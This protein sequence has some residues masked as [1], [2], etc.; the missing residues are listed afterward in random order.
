MSV[1]KPTIAELRRIAESYGFDLSEAD[2]ETLSNLGDGTLQSYAR[3]DQ[4]QAPKLPVKYPRNAGW[5]PTAQENPHNAWAWRCSIKGSGE[6]LL[7]GR[8]VALKDNICL[9]G[10]PMRN[11]SNVLDGFVPDEDATVVTRI[12]DAGGE[13]AGKAVCENFC[14]SGGS[15][16]SDGNPV[17]NPADP[18]RSTGGSSSGSGALVAAG[19]VDMA[20][21]GDQGGSIRIPSSWCGIV[22]L[23]PTHGLVPYTGI[24]PI[25]STLDH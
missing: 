6:G 7:A 17:K 19:A 16:T 8:T 20:L 13:I 11:G 21:G 10:I 1:T 12:L 22:G 9:A 14:F 4:L 15:H 2:L 24:F 3:L 5:A 23:K 18:L 25:E